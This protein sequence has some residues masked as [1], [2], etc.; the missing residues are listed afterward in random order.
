MVAGGLLGPWF[1]NLLALDTHWYYYGMD[2]HS[3]FIPTHTHMSSMT[4]FFCFFLWSW[5]WLQ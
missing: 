5:L 1:H 2:V 4:F 3:L